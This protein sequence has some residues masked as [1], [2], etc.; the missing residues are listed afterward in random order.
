MNILLSILSI[1]CFSH[2]DELHQSLWIHETGVY[3]MSI[4]GN[5]IVMDTIASNHSPWRGEGTFD[6]NGFSIF[7]IDSDDILKLK[8]FYQF[9]RDGKNI[10]GF[11]CRDLN[12]FDVKD[13]VK[14]FYWRLPLFWW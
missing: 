4:Q 2:H 11:F 13:R 5:S 14:D 10:V 9:S 6:K 3:R 7:W 12:N 8:G 1:L